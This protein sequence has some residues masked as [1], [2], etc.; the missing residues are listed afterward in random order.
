MI[1][2]VLIHVLK[3]IVKVLQIIISVIAM[4]VILERDVMR[5]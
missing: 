4:K 2:V 3:E 1:Y 5:V